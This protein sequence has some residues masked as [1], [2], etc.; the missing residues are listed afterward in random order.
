MHMT[1]LKEKNSDK[2]GYHVEKLPYPTKR[3]CLALDLKNDPELI[4]Q[5]KHHHSPQHYWA[6]IGEGIKKSGLPVMEIY[7]VDNRMFMVCEMPVEIDFD[8]AWTTISTCERQ[9]EWTALMAKFQQALPGHKL[10]WV[11]MK[12]VFGIPQ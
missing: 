2:N 3:V 10:E 5:Y 12:K 7:L 8:S 9:N 11:K 6:E 1:A 4:E